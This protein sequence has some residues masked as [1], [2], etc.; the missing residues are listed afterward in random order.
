MYGCPIFNGTK[1][2]GMGWMKNGFHFSQ[3]KTKLRESTLKGSLCKMLFRSRGC[4]IVH[5]KGLKRV[6]S[7]VVSCV[8]FF[9]L[10]FHVWR[11]Y[12][13]CF[14]K[15]N[16]GQKFWKFFY[17]KIYFRLKFFWIDFFSEFLF[18]NFF[19]LKK[20]ICFLIYE[21]KFFGEFF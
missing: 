16:T 13:S 7:F 4:F 15:L 20:L 10:G 21:K 8:I 11:I 2:T 9:L 19:I 5:E 12:F 17:D 3:E 1:D 14:E 18:C 6:E